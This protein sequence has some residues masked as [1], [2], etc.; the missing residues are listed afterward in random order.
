MVTP[1]GWPLALRLIVCA[2]PL[3][4]AVPIVEVPL[5]PCAALRL[6]GLAEIEKSDATTLS[7][8]VVEWLPLAAVPGTVR[9]S[10]RGAEDAPTLTVIVDAPPAETDAGLK[11]TVVPAGAL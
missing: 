1:P 5:C 2:A 9:V 7:A 3:R 8:T 4:T 6:P 10:H 11:P